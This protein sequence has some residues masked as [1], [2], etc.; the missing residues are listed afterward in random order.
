[1]RKSSFIKSLWSPF[2]PF[3]LKV[4]FGKT[5][6]GV[7]YFFPRKWVKDPNNPGRSKCV[8]KLIGFD[9]CGL[10]WKTKWDD[11]DYRFEWAPVLSFVAFGYQL[12]IT[13]MVDNPNQYWEAWLYYEHNTDKS[14]TKKERIEQCK[15]EFPQI[16]TVYRQGNEEV[17]NYYNLILRDKYIN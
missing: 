11:T 1:M 4:Y 3:K 16:Y 13:A 9:F 6:V 5:Q 15:K 7:P 17:V 8:P 10:G 14:K 12:A 2:K